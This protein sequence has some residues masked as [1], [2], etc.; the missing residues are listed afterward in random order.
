M[1][2]SCRF[3]APATVR[4]D[5]CQNVWTFNIQDRRVRA[6]NQTSHTTVQARVQGGCAY[7]SDFTAATRP[8]SGV[9]VHVLDLRGVGETM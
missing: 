7:M 1:Q 5:L 4:V 6:R 3:K 2:R 9:T 8:S